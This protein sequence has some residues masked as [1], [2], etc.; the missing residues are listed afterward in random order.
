MTSPESTRVAYPKPT[1]P[2]AF[3]AVGAPGFVVVGGWLVDDE[4]DAL[5]Q[6]SRKYV[7]Y[8]DVLANSTI[9]AAGVR[10]LLGLVGKPNWKVE[11]ADDSPLAREYAEAVE[12]MMHDMVTPWHRV[13]RR[14]AMFRLYG[15]SIQEWTAKRREDGLV[16]LLDV[17][18]RAQRTIER[19]DVD[20]RGEVLGVVQ[21]SPQDSREIYLPRQKLVYLVDDSI[22]DNPEGLGLFRHLV[23]A[24]RRLERLELMEA[25]G[26][27]SDLRGI[28]V[29][30]AP[31]D[32]LQDLPA[33]DAAA[34]RQPLEA[35]IRNHIKSPGMGL[36]LD[37]APYKSIGD[38]QAPS[39][40]PM[41]DVE[42]LRGE[43]GPHA[44]V[45]AAIERVNR[46]LA[47]VLGVEQL[48]LGADS[49]GSHA[50]A[51]DKTQSFGLLV[52]STLVELARSF[53][54][55]LLEPLWRLNGWD[56]ALIPTLKPDQ[57]QYR[58]I[59]QVTG[60]LRDLSQA[61]APVMPGDPAV[62]EVRDLLGLSRPPAVDLSL[63]GMPP[64]EPEPPAGEEPDDDAVPTE[65]EE[66]GE[67]PE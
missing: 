59:E 67:E 10:Y 25:W 13:V 43:N 8:A 2:S 6:G 31:L 45:A 1:K 12:S 44:E 21:R 9:V 63:G 4:R 54:A 27:E 22:N 47:R 52:D 49:R 17:E 18:P 41:Y 46:E 35:F 60:A 14:A 19:W 7:T 16:G 34:I 24:A 11:P 50:L 66:A 36:L 15:F 38:T 57:V 53:E 65:P 33:E 40:V 28:P 26:F 62:D 29:V 37:S 20:L 32:I 23:K 61:G 5:L 58:D 55:D 51:V 42:L 3:R 39:S 64:A 48:L 30:R 56:R